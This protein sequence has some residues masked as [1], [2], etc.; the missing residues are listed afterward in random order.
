MVGYGNP[1]FFF[2]ILLNY[3]DALV[4]KLH[5]LAVVEADK[6]VVFLEFE[7][8]LKLC[9][10]VAKLVFGYQ[11]AIQQQFDGIVK[12][13]PANAVFIVFHPDVKRLDVEMPL[14]VVNFLEYGVALGR[15]P[16]SFT[17]KIFR[18]DLF[19]C[20]K[21]FLRVFHPDKILP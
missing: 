18:K 3:L 8:P 20:F 10:V 14:G 7:R 13:G 19:N 21:C 17:F 9:A 6:V 5:H 4:V 2:N 15:F 16:V 1:Q 12:G 11:V